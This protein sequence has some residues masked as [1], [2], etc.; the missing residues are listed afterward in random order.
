VPPRN[1]PEV[2]QLSQDYTLAVMIIKRGEPLPVD[3]AMRLTNAGYNIES[4]ERIYF[5]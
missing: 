3:L 2:R 4:M 1:L 5:A